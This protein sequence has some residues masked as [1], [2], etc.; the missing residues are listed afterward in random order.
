MT[1]LMN[2]IVFCGTGVGYQS[3]RVDGRAWFDMLLNKYFERS[4]FGVGGNLQAT[5]PKT[6]GGEQFY[7]DRHQYLTF[8]VAPTLALACTAK[9]S[10]IRFNVSAQH[11]VTG[12]ADGAPEL[13]QHR[14]GYLIRAKSKNAMQRFGGKTIFSCGQVPSGSEP[15]SQ[16]HSG[17]MKDCAG[18]GWLYKHIP[19]DQKILRQ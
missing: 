5:T 17:V 4:S 19:M 8:G 12:M 10:L 2:I 16:R 11:I 13:V 9:D 1:F 3:I 18:R 6:L 15:N 14:P 7:G